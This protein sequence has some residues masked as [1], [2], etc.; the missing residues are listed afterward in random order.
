LINTIPLIAAILKGFVRNWKSIL[1]LIVFPLMLIGTVFFSFNPNGLQKIPIGI[2]SQVDGFNLEEYQDTYLSYLYLQKYYTVD[3]CISALKVYKEYVCIEVINESSAF[4]LNIYYDNTREPVIWEIIERIKATIDLLQKQKSKETAA[5]FLTKFNTNLNKLENFKGNLVSTN[6]KLDTYISGADSAIQLSSTAKSEASTAIKSMDSELNNMKTL[7]KNIDSKKKVYSDD[8][9]IRVRAV[10]SLSST[11]PNASSRQ[12]THLSYI[13]DENT[14]I[15]NQLNVYNEQTDRYLADFDNKIRLYELASSAGKQQLTTIDSGITKLNEIKNELQSYRNKISNAETEI[16]NIQSEFDSIKKLDPESLVNP[17][18]LR[19]KPT[20][21]PEVSKQQL[22]AF[23]GPN[24]AKNIVKGVSLISL[25]TIFPTILFLIALFL[26]LLISSFICLAEIN[27]PVSQRIKLVKRI[28]LHQLLSVY[29][30]TLIIMIVPLF[31]V[32]LLGDF[33]F[34]IAILANIK[35]V[36]VVLFLVS[37]IFI[38]LGMSLAYLIKKESITLL[39]TAFILVFLIFFSGFLLPIER[40][41]NVASVL[42][43]NFPAKMGLAAFNKVVF[44]N[45]GFEAI[46]HNIFVLSAWFLSLMI[47]TLIIKKTKNI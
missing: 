37:S 26:S 12:L 9:I 8:T 21:V 11:V 32:I 7:R 42:A 46:S 23:T 39:V 34:K 43:A 40:M 6:T 2:V 24:Q 47:I 44:Y 14:Q 19:N 28:F 17:I 10:D 25:Q 35:I 1:L 18:V 38:F 33:L 36:L 4:L 3:K 45:Q 22:A 20:Y 16:I 30:S 29:I 5:G 13:K 15:K 27:S 41:S 31:S